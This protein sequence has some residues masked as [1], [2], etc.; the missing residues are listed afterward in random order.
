MMIAEIRINSTLVIVGSG[1]VTRD[2]TMVGRGDDP[3]MVRG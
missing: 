1:I 3:D 2:D